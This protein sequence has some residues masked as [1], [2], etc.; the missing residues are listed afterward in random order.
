MVAAAMNP[1]VE[2]TVLLTLNQLALWFIWLSM[3]LGSGTVLLSWILVKVWD[4]WRRRYH[5]EECR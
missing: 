4:G 2:I 1:Q 5:K 3:I